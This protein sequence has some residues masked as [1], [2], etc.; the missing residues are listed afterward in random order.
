[1]Q[2]NGIEHFDLFDDV[3]IF[4]AEIS[5]LPEAIQNKARKIDGGEY[6]ADCFGMCA[7]Y[8]LTTK[9]FAIVTDTDPSTG[10][11]SNIYYVDDNGDKHWFKAD[12]TPEFVNQIFSECAKIQEKENAVQG[13]E[14]KKSV[15]FEDGRGF[16]LAENPKAPSPFVVWQFTEQNGRRDYYWGHYHGGRET[17]EKELTARTADHRQY[18]R[19]KEEK[20]P[21]A[22]QLREA[23]KQAKENRGPAAPKKD[24]PDKGDR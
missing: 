14:I 17:A 24:A 1:M 6:R 12:I 18:C 16:A 23:A 3:T 21:I 11:Y 7:A 2:F 22:E 10:D 13:Y 8:D 5:D 9:E 4:W 19:V 20:R 15:L